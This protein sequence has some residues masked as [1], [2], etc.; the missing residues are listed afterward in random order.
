MK[1]TLTRIGLGL[2]TLGLIGAIQ[3]GIWTIFADDSRGPEVEIY[4]VDINKVRAIWA[5]ELR[6]V[7]SPEGKVGPIRDYFGEGAERGRNGLDNEGLEDPLSDEEIPPGGMVIV[8]IAYPEN[9]GGIPII[10][11][12]YD[13]VRDRY[14]PGDQLPDNSILVSVDR[15]A[16]GEYVVKRSRGGKPEKEMRFVGDKL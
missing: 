12:E 4:S 3:G 8:S 2:L 6:I 1:E 15:I 14:I 7:D 10:W 16:P 9:V 13:D 11:I 5:Q